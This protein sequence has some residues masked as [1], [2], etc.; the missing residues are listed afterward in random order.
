MQARGQAGRLARRQEKS[1]KGSL[2]FWSILVTLGWFEN[3]KTKLTEHCPVTPLVLQGVR[4]FMGFWVG[5][6]FYQE[7]HGMV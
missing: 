5:F 2:K 6:L 7:A 1:I 3:L 4:N